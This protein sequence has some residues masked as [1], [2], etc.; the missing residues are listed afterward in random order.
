MN[1]PNVP[2]GHPTDLL[3]PSRVALL[4]GV[5]T[6]TVD[7]WVKTGQLTAAPHAVG[8]HRYPASAVYQLLDTASSASLD[9]TD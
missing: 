4:L 7:Q 5:D 2:P 6:N 8:H 9:A 3:T 1:T